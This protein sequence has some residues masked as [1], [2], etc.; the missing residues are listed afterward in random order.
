MRLNA[1][2]F[3]GKWGNLASATLIIGSV[4]VETF[5]LR[6]LFHSVLGS[7]LLSLGIHATDFYVPFFLGLGCLLVAVG[8]TAPLRLAPQKIWAT[9]NVI[10]L[11]ITWL[12]LQLSSNSKLPVPLQEG[13]LGMALLLAC[14]AM[15]TSLVLW[16]PPSLIRLAVAKSPRMFIGMLLGTILLYS[17]PWLLARVWTPLSEWTAYCTWRLLQLSGSDVMKVQ[18]DGNI[19][20]LH[21]RF[22]ASI[23]MGCSGLDGIFF[24]L[25]SYIL[26]TVIDRAKPSSVVVVVSIVT[27]C[28]MM[29]LLNVVRITAFFALAVA[30]QK[31]LGVTRSTD[32]IMWLFHANVGWILYLA[33]V[34][35]FFRRLSGVLN[36]TRTA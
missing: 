15:A 34:W 29:F 31:N 20:I 22:Y 25:Y 33:A 5:V 14:G 16:L 36:T 32:L 17:Y 2:E 24:F 21:R 8:R 23:N 30:L 11:T 7:N 6:F 13:F 19:T 18:S 10:L 28:L 27:G 12:V 26:W 9:V 1:K 4:V 35:L 3:N